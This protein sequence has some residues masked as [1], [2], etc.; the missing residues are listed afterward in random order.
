MERQ[1]L[2]RG[3]GHRLLGLVE[4]DWRWW[5][6]DAARAASSSNSGS[7]PTRT[8][9]GA[10]VDATVGWVVVG[11]GAVGREIGRDG[12][13]SGVLGQV[14]CALRCDAIPQPPAPSSILSQLLFGLTLLRGWSAA[15]S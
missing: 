15:I 8:L 12:L 2:A 5:F 4:I 13:G 3:T 7:L 11:W 14:E 6:L 9:D 1:T 10:M